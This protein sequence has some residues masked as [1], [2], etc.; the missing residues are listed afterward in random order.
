MENTPN[1]LLINPWIYDFAAHDL[2]S[3][4]LGLLMLAGLLRAQGYNLRML[5]CL[6]VHDSRLQAIPGMKSATRRAFGTG[7]FYRTQVPKPSSLQQFH[8][9]YYRFGIT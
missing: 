7:K 9:N 4:P 6:D 2:W 3:K 1:I 5:D 8:R